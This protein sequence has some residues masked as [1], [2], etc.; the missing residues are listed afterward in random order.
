MQ[1]LRIQY[2]EMSVIWLFLTNVLQHRFKVSFFF[3]SFINRLFTLHTFPARPNRRFDRWMDS[4]QEEKREKSF[5]RLF[6]PPGWCRLLDTCSIPHRQRLKNHGDDSHFQEP[7][8][9]RFQKQFHISPS[10]AF[11]SSERKKR[12]LQDK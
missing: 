6:L 12:I 4:N 8:E 9:K 3:F 10:L 1:Q 5:V 2:L 7:E 11:E